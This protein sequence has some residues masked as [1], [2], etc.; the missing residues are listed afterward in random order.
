MAFTAPVYYHNHTQMVNG[1]CG[2]WFGGGRESIGRKIIKDHPL[3]CG[4]QQ[5]GFIAH[6]SYALVITKMQLENKKKNELGQKV[7]EIKGNRRSTGKKSQLK[8]KIS[9]RQFPSKTQLI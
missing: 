2:P 8:N 5:H 1:F 7:M 6:N 3:R 9:F 4:Q